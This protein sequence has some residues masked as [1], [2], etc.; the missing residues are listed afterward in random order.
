MKTYALAATCIQHGKDNDITHTLVF[1]CEACSPEEAIGKFYTKSLKT[2]Y[3]VRD[4]VLQ[5]VK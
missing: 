4:I 1:S 3:P 5:E 2:A